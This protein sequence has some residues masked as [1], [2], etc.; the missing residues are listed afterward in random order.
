VVGDGAGAGGARASVVVVDAGVGEVVDANW[1]C[2]SSIVVTTKSLAPVVQVIWL[3]MNV[4]PATVA[5][6]SG[7]MTI[8]HA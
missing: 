7:K 2:V 8:S 1:I 5:M 4:R 3:I 6:E